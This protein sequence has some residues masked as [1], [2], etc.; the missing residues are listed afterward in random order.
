MG[1]LLVEEEKLL[2][3]MLLLAAE[4]EQLRR[5]LA[6]LLRHAPQ[7]RQYPLR[8]SI[9]GPWVPCLSFSSLS[10]PGKRIVGAA[11][12]C[13]APTTTSAVAAGTLVCCLCG[14]CLGPWVARQE[15]DDV[16]ERGSRV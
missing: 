12:P 9:L 13:Q 2:L 5:L 16:G 7:R 6:H 4:L 10:C 8:A 1:P 11:C 14:R 3:H 15:L